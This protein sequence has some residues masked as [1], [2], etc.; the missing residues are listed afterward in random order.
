MILTWLLHFLLHFCSCILFRRC[1]NFMTQTKMVQYQQKSLMQLLLIFHL[2]IHLEFSML[3]GENLAWMLSIRPKFKFEFLLIVSGEWNSD[4]LAMTTLQCIPK[5][6]KLFPG[7]LNSDF[8]KAF[9][10]FSFCPSKVNTFT[11]KSFDKEWIWLSSRE[12]P[13]LPEKHSSS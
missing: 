13:V 4:N 6:S 7:N 9:K 2:L 10:E 11:I 5:F 12:S 8:S 3:T 1:S